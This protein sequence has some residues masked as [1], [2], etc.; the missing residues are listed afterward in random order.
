MGL[1]MNNDVT[2]GHEWETT[3]ANDNKPPAWVSVGRIG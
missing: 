2:S 1:S 3:P